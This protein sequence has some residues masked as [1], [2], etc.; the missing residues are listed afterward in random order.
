M[1]D[2]TELPEVRVLRGHCADGNTCP[3]ILDIGDPDDLLVVGQPETIVARLVATRS[4]VGPGEVVYRVPRRLL[5]EV[6]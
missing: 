2:E 4:H 3:K 6:R 1:A 5:P